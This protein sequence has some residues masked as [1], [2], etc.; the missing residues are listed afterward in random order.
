MKARMEKVMASILIIDDEE[1][2]RNVLQMI[3]EGDGYDVS[4]AP[5][6]NVAMDL[7]RREPVDL[8]ITDIIMPDKD[9]V[10]T[11][12]EVREYFPEIRIIAI[13]GGGGIDPM[14]YKPEAISTTAYLAAATQAGADLVITKPFERDDLLRAVQN[15]LGNLH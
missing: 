11:I 8:L 9:G 13:S 1:D 5:N 2:I 10:S 3:L 7:L 6:G 14:A 12:T 4:I 15:L